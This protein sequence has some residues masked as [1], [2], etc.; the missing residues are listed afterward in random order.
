MFET[1]LYVRDRFAIVLL[2]TVAGVHA[3]RIEESGA[4]ASAKAVW[5]PLKNT[6]RAP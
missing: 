1:R 3:I 5:N 6:P 4:F 2:N